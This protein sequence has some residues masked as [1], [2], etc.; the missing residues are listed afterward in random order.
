MRLLVIEDE[1]TLLSQISN[2]LQKN[3]FAVDGADNGIDGQ[4][5]GLENDYDAAIVDLGLPGIDGINIIQHW[6][7]EQRR[8]PILILT[9]KS[10]WQD[11]VAGLNAGADDYLAKPFH[12]EELYARL[13]ALIRRSAGLADTVVQ[14][15]HMRLD[16]KSKHV[17]LGDKPLAL[18]AYE[19][20]LLEYLALHRGEVCS[21]S[22]LTEH[23]YDQDFERDSNVIE[24]FIRR[25]RKKA[26]ELGE[27]LPLSTV[28]GLGYKLDCD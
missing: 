2:Q 12:Y 11:K 15:G 22:V 4:F 16:T 17:T 20:N 24:V 6:R 14:C 3:G 5:L 13:N 25:L 21:K 9:A 7:A 18:T 27:S 10:N 28:R 1:A 26:E 23:I 19:F 8:F